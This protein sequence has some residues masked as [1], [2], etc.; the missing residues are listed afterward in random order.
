MDSC[1]QITATGGLKTQST[2]R[3]G[4][5]ISGAVNTQMATESYQNGKLTS[6]KSMTSLKDKTTAKGGH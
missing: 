3:V 5:V 2:A 4:S 6:F 1:D